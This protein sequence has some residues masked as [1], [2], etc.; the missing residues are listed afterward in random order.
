M[1][2]HESTC[3]RMRGAAAQ[4]SRLDQVRGNR[5]ELPDGAR[6]CADGHFHGEPAAAGVAG[7]ERPELFVD[8]DAGARVGEVA[9]DG[10]GDAWRGGGCGGLWGFVGCGQ[11]RRGG[12]RGGRVGGGAGG[13]PA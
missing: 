4:G 7:E 2:A 8:G 1:H 12:R 5:G 11:E 6:G 13:A 10:G 9:D 3:T